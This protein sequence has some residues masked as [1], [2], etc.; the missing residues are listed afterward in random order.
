MTDILM[1]ALAVLLF[2]LLAGVVRYAGNGVKGDQE[3]VS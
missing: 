1:I 3:P 2:A